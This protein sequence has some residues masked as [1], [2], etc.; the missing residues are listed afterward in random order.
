MPITLQ[1]CSTEPDGWFC[2]LNSSQL[3]NSVGVIF[4]FK[5]R[6]KNYELQ[7]IYL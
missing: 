1:H 3:I 7:H 2:N 5:N 4:I 6:N